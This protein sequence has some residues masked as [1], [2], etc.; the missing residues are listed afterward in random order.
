MADAA[1]VAELLKATQ[2]FASLDPSARHAIAQQMRPANFSNGE[3]IFSSGDPGTEI[4][5]VVQGRVRVS[6]LSLEGRELSFHHIERGMVFG[7]IAALDGGGRTADATAI[8][9]VQTMTL[10]QVAL[11]R[12][13]EQTPALAL[14][15]INLVCSNLR[16]ADEQL[17]AIALHSL[18]VRLARYILEQLRRHP[19]SATKPAP[20]FIMEISQ[21]ELA[22]RLGASRPKVNFAISSLENQGAITRHGNRIECDVALL[23]D[24]AG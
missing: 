10:S 23:E 1:T 7:E 13:I 21:T 12:A 3:S 11:R 17:V 14:A 9:N 22:L 20:S 19:A 6:A 15:A 18:E 2:L 8:T 4:Y 24:I 16:R 5:L